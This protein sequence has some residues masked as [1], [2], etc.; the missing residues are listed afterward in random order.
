MGFKW[1]H[2]LWGIEQLTTQSLP[3]RE[4]DLGRLHSCG[5]VR[6]DP[7][8]SWVRSAV[9]VFDI[10]EQKCPEKLVEWMPQI[11]STTVAVKMGS[12][13]LGCHFPGYSWDLR[14]CHLW[15]LQWILP[16]LKEVRVRLQPVSAFG[17][18]PTSPQMRQVKYE[19]RFVLRSDLRLE[20]GAASQ[21]RSLTC[22][23]VGPE[24]SHW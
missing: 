7:R 1:I 22:V 13:K 3:S 6:G 2:Q 15:G 9:R 10:S 11:P 14:E 19:T 23:R 17:T 8:G 24:M 5:G 21:F 16:Q 12:S 4:V 20:G 18:S